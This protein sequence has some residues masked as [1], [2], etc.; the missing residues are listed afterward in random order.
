[1]NV[2]EIIDALSTAPR[3]ALVYI[4]DGRSGVIESCSAY[5]L[6]AAGELQ[7]RATGHE[8]GDV[9]ELPVGT[10]YFTIHVG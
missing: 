6:H 3:D 10:E 2:Q 5:H 4:K 8:D 9:S 1:M 7:H